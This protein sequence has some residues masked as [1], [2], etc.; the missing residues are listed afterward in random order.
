MIFLFKDGRPPGTGTPI[1]LFDKCSFPVLEH[2]MR[3][4]CMFSGGFPT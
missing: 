3:F 2:S 4:V 1:D